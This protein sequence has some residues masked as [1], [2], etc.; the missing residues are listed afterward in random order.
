VVMAALEEAVAV[1]AVAFD[2][3]PFPVPLAIPVVALLAVACPSHARNC[4][5]QC[6]ES[7]NIW[8]Y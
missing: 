7:V 5:N 1:E 4:Q 2:D 8:N 3:A 6:A